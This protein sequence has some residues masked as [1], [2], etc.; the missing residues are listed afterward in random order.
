MEGPN[1]DHLRRPLLMLRAPL[2]L[3]CQMV[4]GVLLVMKLPSFNQA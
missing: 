2:C 3:I 4:A 1:G